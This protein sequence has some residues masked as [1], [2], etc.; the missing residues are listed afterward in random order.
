MSSHEITTGSGQSARSLHAAQQ[1]E[2]VR[3]GWETRRRNKANEAAHLNQLLALRHASGTPEIP[4]QDSTSTLPAMKELSGSPL[5]I[6][7]RHSKSNGRSKTVDPDPVLQ[8]DGCEKRPKKRVMTSKPTLAV[9]AMT[10]GTKSRFNSEPHR[11]KP[12]PDASTANASKRLTRAQ[13]EGG[14]IYLSHMGPYFT[15]GDAAFQRMMRDQDHDELSEDEELTVY[16]PPG[17]RLPSDIQAMLD[18]PSEDELTKAQMA[19][20]QPLHSGNSFHSRYLDGRHP[21]YR[22]QAPGNPATEADYP[23]CAELSQ[24]FL[25]DSTT[26]PVHDTLAPEFYLTEYQKRRDEEFAGLKMEVPLMETEL[27]LMRA[28]FEKLESESSWPSALGVRTVTAETRAKHADHRRRAL[29]DLKRHLRTREAILAARYELIEAESRDAR[30]RKSRA[31]EVVDDDR[32]K[33]EEEER[34]CSRS[35][36]RQ[37]RAMVDPVSKVNGKV[38]EIDLNAGN[39]GSKEG[40]RKARK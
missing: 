23:R 22:Y 5:S 28:L 19:S 1:S 2:R 17:F 29:R 39:I 31:K 9:T 36:R 14:E 10:N 13:A 8:E 33:E 35:R 24:A 16:E 6:R 21:D 26:Q 3:R 30:E 12:G 20:R 7:L 25:F 40:G 38:A 37:R 4:Q 18:M 11:P 27:A 15:G 34:G 32:V